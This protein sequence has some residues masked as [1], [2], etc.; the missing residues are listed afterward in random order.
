MGHSVVI[1]LISERI[2]RAAVLNCWQNPKMGSLNCGIKGIIMRSSR[3]PWTATSPLNWS[4]LLRRKWQVT[5]MP[6]KTNVCQNIIDKPYK[7]S[8]AYHIGEDFRVQRFVACQDILS[9]L[10]E[11]IFNVFY[12]CIDNIF[13]TPSS[14]YSSSPTSFP[15]LPPPSFSLLRFAKI[16]SILIAFPK[17]NL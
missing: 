6:C 15:L 10:M 13:L 4:N 12:I 11:N 1:F 2:I 16:S 5:W 17:H 9:K 8:E 7:D 3:S 14:F